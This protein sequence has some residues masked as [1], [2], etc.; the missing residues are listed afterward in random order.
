[1]ASLADII[2]QGIERKRAE[3]ELLQSEQR[4]RLLFER[5]PQ[6]M[7]VFDLETLASSRSTTPPSI[8]TDTRGK[9]SWR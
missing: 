8:I 5:N 6:P 7:W 9:N 4:Y 1:M 3:E 2:S